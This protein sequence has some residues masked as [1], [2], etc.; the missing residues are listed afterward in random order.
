MTKILGVDPGLTRCGFGLVD[1]TKP[2][3][4][5]VFQTDSKSEP[6]ARVVEISTRLGRV[7]DAYRPDLIALE[8]VFAKANLR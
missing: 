5:G 8:R 4:F 2:I 6:S 7:I 3:E 1:G